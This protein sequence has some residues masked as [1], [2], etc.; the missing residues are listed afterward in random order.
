MLFES[1]AEA[2]LRHQPGMTYAFRHPAAMDKPGGGGV[3]G[4]GGG[5]KSGGGA[6]G[7]RGGLTL[8]LTEPS[9]CWEVGV[10][11]EFGIC[12]HE[13]VGWGVCV[14]LMVVVVVGRGVGRWGDVRRRIGTGGWAGDRKGGWRGMC[15]G[16]GMVRVYRRTARTLHPA[17]SPRLVSPFLASPPRPT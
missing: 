8:K 16:L 9:Q 5:G 12:G 4:G 13:T 2:Q 11:A 14:L 17:E 3:G 6:G 1:M 15:D 10:A 7:E